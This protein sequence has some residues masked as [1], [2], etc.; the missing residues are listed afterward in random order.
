MPL[1]EMVEES[2]RELIP[3]R[4]YPFTHTTCFNQHVRAITPFAR[5]MIVDDRAYGRAD[6]DMDV[7]RNS[8]VVEKRTA[9]GPFASQ[10]G[11]PVDDHEAA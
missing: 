3:R 10:H 4:L 2:S 9:W 6:P 8:D 1:H 11:K 7:G 5:D